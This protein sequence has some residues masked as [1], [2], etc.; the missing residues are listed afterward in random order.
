MLKKPIIVSENVG[1]K[2]MVKEDKNGYIFENENSESLKKTIEKIIENK[3]KLNEM[4][5]ISRKMYEDYASFEF[6]KQEL[7]KLITLL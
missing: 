7:Q 4:G 5:E 2:Y 3:N 1:A 6:H